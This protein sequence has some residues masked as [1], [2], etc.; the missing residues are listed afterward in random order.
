MHII[1]YLDQGT[2]L[3]KF[4]ELGTIDRELAFLKRLVKEKYK[5]SLF[6]WAKGEDKK[7]VKKINPIKLVENKKKIRSRLWVIPELIRLMRK[8]KNSILLT[9]QTFG[10]EWALIASK[11]TKTTMIARS[12][13]PLSLHT[14]KLYGK[15][16]LIYIYFKFVEFFVFKFAE[17]IITTSEHQ[18]RY[19]SKKRKKN[20]F[21]L[22][23]YVD[24]EKF[25]TTRK[26]KNNNKLTLVFTGR[27]TKQ[28]NLEFL[29]KSIKNIKNIKLKIVGEGELRMQLEN[30]V[31]E[32]SLPVEF[33]GQKKNIELKN[34][35]RTADIFIF[36]S[37]YEGNPKAMLEAMASRLPVIASNV[38]GI[39]QIIIDNV[40]GFLFNENNSIDLSGKIE[41]LRS[42]RE[43]RRIGNNAFE[44]IKKNHNLKIYLMKLKQILNDK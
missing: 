3:S 1:F 4:N 14:K 9:N 37:I 13:F 6:S 5:I 22:P 30:Y 27:L 40:N 31:N 43:R 33:L 44:Y 7:F 34:I 36:P 16:S 39:K 23:N 26:Y 19:I 29:L 12:G 11:L 28:K 32:N 38:I 24:I 42:S 25:D 15:F 35:Y 18:Y 2:T 21:L 41:K 20:I 8:N 10:S 17:K